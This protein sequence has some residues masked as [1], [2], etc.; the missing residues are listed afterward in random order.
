MPTES[1]D[2][3]SS[4]KGSGA[5]KTKKR[6]KQSQLKDASIIE[7][8]QKKPALSESSGPEACSIG[9]AITNFQFPPNN[10]QNLLQQISITNQAKACAEEEYKEFMDELEGNGKESTLKCDSRHPDSVWETIKIQNDIKYLERQYAKTVSIIQGLKNG[11]PH[12]INDAKATVDELGN[13]TLDKC[14][15]NTTVNSGDASIPLQQPLLPKEKNHSLI[16]SLCHNPHRKQRTNRKKAV[17]YAREIEEKTKR[18]LA[19]RVNRAKESDKGIKENLL[20]QQAESQ[21]LNCMQSKSSHLTG[22]LT[23]QIPSGTETKTKRH[24]KNQPGDQNKHSSRHASTGSLANSAAEQMNPSAPK[25][26]IVIST[27]V[28]LPQKP[29]KSSHKKNSQALSQPP[30]PP[31]INNSFEVIPGKELVHKE[32]QM[33]LNK[34]I[35]HQQYMSNGNTNL[36]TKA[37][38]KRSTALQSQQKTQP[39]Y[40]NMPNMQK[41]QMPLPQQKQPQPQP[42]P[43]QQQQQLQQNPTLVIGAQS[44]GVMPHPGPI[45]PHQMQHGVNQNPQ[46][47]SYPPTFHFNPVPM[48]HPNIIRANPANIQIIQNK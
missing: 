45:A 3:L 17:E 12:A 23:Q 1:T 26:S 34:K 40:P 24:R 13:C 4:S 6:Q 36:Q 2:S 27:T 38:S 10:Q 9:P 21:R 5:T 48:N 18:D 44:Y 33:M 41:Q 29:G 16:K 14:Q 35:E 19:D 47:P 42:Q 28:P 37:Q 7:P 11:T 8:L 15:Q 25:D 39:Q 43:Q 30:Q 46:M 32:H 31:Q 22:S 20:K